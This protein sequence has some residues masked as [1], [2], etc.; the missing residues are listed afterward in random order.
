MMRGDGD[1]YRGGDVELLGELEVTERLAAVRQHLLL[2][3]AGPLLH[4]DDGVDLLGG[5]VGG[6]SGKEG[7]REGAS[8]GSE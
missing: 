8:G 2:C 6:V 5:G 3:E 7:G 1:V 4:G